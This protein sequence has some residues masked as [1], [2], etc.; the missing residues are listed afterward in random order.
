MDK[1]CEKQDFFLE[2]AGSKYILKRNNCH[3]YQVQC[4]P[5]ITGAPFCDFIT[6]TRQDLIIGRNYPCVD[7]MSMLLEKMSHVYVNYFKPYYQSKN[8]D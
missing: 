6:F 1:A 2:R 7:T 5:L 4:Q 3:W 8:Q